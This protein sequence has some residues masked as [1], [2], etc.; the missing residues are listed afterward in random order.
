MS[1]GIAP[2]APLWWTRVR[3]GCRRRRL[4]Q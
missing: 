1:F 3:K 4:Q 2:V